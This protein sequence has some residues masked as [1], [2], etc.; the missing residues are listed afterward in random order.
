MNSDIIGIIAFWAI[1]VLVVL[2]ITHNK[3]KKQ[4]PSITTAS[5]P[6]IDIKQITVENYAQSYEPKWLL[7]YNEKNAYQKIKS[8][9]EEQGYTVFVKVRL[10]DLIQ[11]RIKTD[12][13]YLWKVQSKHVD[14]VICDSKLVAKWVIELEDNSHNTPERKAR[15]QFVRTILTNCGYFVHETYNPNDKEIR[16]FLGISNPEEINDSL[17]K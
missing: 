7:S 2:L 5:N 3:T 12:K 17:C 8:V 9:A 11:P 1:I 10:L 6:Q 15:D 4:T 14:F 16:Q 13:K